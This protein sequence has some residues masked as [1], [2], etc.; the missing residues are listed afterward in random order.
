MEAE[1]TIYVVDDDA[2]V[3]R[4][5]AGA[6]KLL[7]RPVREFASAA[8]FLAAFDPAQPGCLVLDIKMPDMTGVELQQKLAADRVALPIV[9]VS[10]HAD[11]RTAVEVMTRGA[12]TLLEKPFRLDELLTHVRRALEMDAE[13]R[14][15]TARKA[16]TDARLA[17]LTA[18]E[19]EVL[20]AV[21]AG[22]TNRE[23]AEELG[24]SLR[25][26][27]DRRARLMKKVQARSVAELV[28]L[29]PPPGAASG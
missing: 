6:G 17:G 9:V 14:A 20:E 8:E 21:A 10:G 5:I 25:A 24:L 3:R 27:E 29:L 4:A 23:I 12:V 1:P 2:A 18:K 16:E 26:V 7:G 13:A 28:Q 19:R 22:K 11:V 15:R